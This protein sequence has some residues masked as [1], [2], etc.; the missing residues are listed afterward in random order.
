MERCIYE[1]K[2][3]IT[4]KFLVSKDEKKRVQGTFEKYAFRWRQTCCLVTT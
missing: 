4:K 3:S 2:V 1:A